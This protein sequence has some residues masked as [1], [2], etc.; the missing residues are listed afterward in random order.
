MCGSSDS[1]SSFC[2]LSN[3]FLLFQLHV[4]K[5]KK[6]MQQQRQS[7]WSLSPLLCGSTGKDYGINGQEHHSLFA[8]VRAKLLLAEFQGL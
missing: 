2:L 3:Y 6:K 4:K 7:L 5:K 8:E 1:A